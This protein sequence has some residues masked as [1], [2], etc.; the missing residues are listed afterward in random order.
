MTDL[1]REPLI[2]PQR[3]RWVAFALTGVAA[4]M[5]GLGFAAVPLY[6]VFCQVTG[7]GGT[8]Q[9][10][11]ANMKGVIDRQMTVRFD[12]NVARLPWSVEPAGPV[13]ARVGEIQNVE[14]VARNN[15]DHPVTGKAVFNVTPEATG[16]Y[17]NKIQC[18]CFTR[19]TLQPGEQ[20]RMPVVFFV[21]PDIAKNHDLDSVRDITLSYTFY[22]ADKQGS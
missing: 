9:R 4:A 15:A 6:S 18:F 8:T 5:L 2:S 11:A 20:V 17:F 10:S 19:Q 14:F 12:S 21:D 7:Y 16:S 22:S 3:N 13:T 1:P